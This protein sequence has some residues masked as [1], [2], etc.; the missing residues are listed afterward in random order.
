MAMGIKQ[1]DMI[2]PK[3][4][5]R[6]FKRSPQM[7]GPVVDPALGIVGESRLGGKV[8]TVWPGGKPFANHAFGDA[9]AVDIGGIQKGDPVIPGG[10][11]RAQRFRLVCRAIGTAKG[12][13]AQTKRR[14]DRPV[15]AKRA[16]LPGVT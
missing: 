8:G 10:I 9:I 7:F 14:Y 1:R 11:Q 16:G 15:T 4:A 12:K 5:Q 13:R 3:P 2:T 6:R